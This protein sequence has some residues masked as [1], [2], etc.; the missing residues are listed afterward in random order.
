MDEI[1]Y[2]DVGSKIQ[3]QF[4]KQQYIIRTL[5]NRQIQ[6]RDKH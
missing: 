3:G 2:V 5:F 6:S 1:P 4:Q